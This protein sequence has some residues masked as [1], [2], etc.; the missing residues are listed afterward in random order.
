MNLELSKPCQETCSTSSYRVA[1][2]SKM[3]WR[4]PLALVSLLAGMIILFEGV[5]PSPSNFFDAGLIFLG[6]S[7]VTGYIAILGDI[8]GEWM[9]ESPFKAFA[10]I[11]SCSGV[12]ILL[13]SGS[14][15]YTLSS[16]MAM[17]ITGFVLLI[18]PII[19]LLKGF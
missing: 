4:L 19:L 8:F 6:L 16:R 14:Q 3:N 11:I 10:P 5:S 17:A 13:Q 12:A 7:L 2:I 1:R 15:L 18:L 9:S